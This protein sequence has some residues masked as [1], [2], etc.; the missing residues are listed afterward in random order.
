MSGEDI[1]A[2]GVRPAIYIEE[3]AR[4]F[5]MTVERLIG[6][7]KLRKYA[8]A[9]QCCMVLLCRNLRLST[10]RAGRLLGGRDHTT[11]LHGLKVIEGNMDV[12]EADL[13]VI[14]HA[15]DERVRKYFDTLQ[16]EAVEAG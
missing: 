12:Y 11:V 15:A 4:H 9:R 13:S 10:S 14:E 7:Q 2:F 16:A 5:G 3:T 1:R 8:R 6:P